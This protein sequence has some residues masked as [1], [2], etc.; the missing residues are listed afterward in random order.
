MEV[1]NSQ[2]EEITRH[3]FY[4]L[5]E[6]ES[7]LQSLRMELEVAPTDHKVHRDLFSRIIRDAQ[8]GLRLPDP[9]DYVDV[10]DPTFGITVEDEQEFDPEIEALRQ[11]GWKIMTVSQA[12]Q[13]VA[14]LA[15]GKSDT[16]SS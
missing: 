14:Q 7:L 13:N 10:D 4:T 11:Q 9:N 12:A 3:H 16:P 8:R 6:L 2:V 1:S 15:D 5:D